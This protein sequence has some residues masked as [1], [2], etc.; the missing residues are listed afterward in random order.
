M[1]PLAC[2]RATLIPLLFRE[3]DRAQRMKAPLSLMALSPFELGMVNRLDRTANCEDAMGQIAERASRFLRSY[4]LIGRIALDEFLL[5]LPDCDGFNASVVAARLRKDLFA[6]PLRI[7]RQQIQFS[8]SFGVATSFGRSPI[9]VMREA[10]SALQAARMEAPGS[11]HCYASCP[12]TE[13][14]AA[15]L[16]LPS[17]HSIAT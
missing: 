3:T 6:K 12:E 8:A 4:D 9:V 10:E 11:I 14:E 1:H 5:A 17:A 15:E 13:D 2:D 16:L 7:A